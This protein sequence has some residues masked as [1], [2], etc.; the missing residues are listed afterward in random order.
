M[1]RCIY[2][3]LCKNKTIKV[4]NFISNLVARSKSFILALKFQ[5]LV[6]VPLYKKTI[7][8]NLP[9]DI[10]MTILHIKACNT[11]F[12][13]E[14]MCI[15]DMVQWGRRWLIT[16]M[17]YLRWYLLNFTGIGYSTHEKLSSSVFVIFI[18]TRM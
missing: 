18:R 3:F 7:H 16:V 15:L 2:H 12:I 14:L 11:T 5:A 1:L 10:E 4:L 8:R 6:Y 17:F 13:L 9:K